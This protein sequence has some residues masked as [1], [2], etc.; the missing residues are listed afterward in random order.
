MSDPQFWK[1]ALAVAAPLC[2][3]FGFR[4]W[5]LARLIDDT[6][7]SRIRSAAQ[8]Y[9]ELA[10]V[11]RRNDTLATLGPLTRL[12]CVWWQFRIEQRT[13]MGRS[14]RW[15]TVNR[16]S[17]VA[18]FRLEDDTGACLVDPAGADVRPGSTASWRGSLPWPSPPGEGHR[19]MALGGGD[20]R[21]TEHR[22]DEQ[23][24][25]SVIGDFRSVGGVEASDVTGEVMRL[26]SD[27]KGDQASLLRTFDADHNG[28]L[29]QAEWEQARATARAQI[30]QRPPEPAKASTNVVRAPQDHRPFL[31]AASDLKVLARR[32]RWAAGALLAGFVLAVGVLT[33]LLT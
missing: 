4:N 6:P 27:W 12:P 20:Y 21:Y 29:S 32:S 11:A 30:E 15:S 5:R 7:R 2:L 24:S 10:G 14:R 17:S 26:L 25:I 13:G 9:V 22:I 28:I 23:A 8:G 16:G 3:Y 33:A 19:L 1:L 18:P 31:V